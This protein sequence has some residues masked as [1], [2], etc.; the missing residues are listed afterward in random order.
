MNRFRFLTAFV[1]LAV[2]CSTPP[3]WSQENLGDEHHRSLQALAGTWNLKIKLADAPQGQEASTGTAKYR[4]ILGGLFV[5]EEVECKLFGQPFQWIGLYGYDTN[6]KKY[7]AT[8][9]DNF[10]TGTEVGEAEPEATG[11]VFAFAG[12]HAIPGGA[13]TKF[14]W[15]IRL[16]AK[17]QIRIEMFEKGADGEEAK[18]LEATATRAE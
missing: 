5:L 3:A 2:A 16:E 1:A 7:T 6:Q 9:A 4:S 15:I 12:E 14:Q 18:V 8:W 11:K 10:D 17:N 13:K